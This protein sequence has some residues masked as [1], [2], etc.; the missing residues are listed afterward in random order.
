SRGR[1]TVGR[2]KGD[3]GVARGPGGPPYQSHTHVASGVIRGV[4]SK[5]G[6]GATMRGLRRTSAV[7]A[8]LLILSVYSFSQAVNATL[9]GTVT[10]AT[11]A[12]IASA[13]VVV[14]EVNTGVSHTG[15]TNESGNFT[16][17]DL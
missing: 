2:R 17:P 15:Q 6:V 1:G 10:D 16:F 7:F 13:K 3:R 9:L 8:L 5:P 11:G 14:T 4:S 12:V